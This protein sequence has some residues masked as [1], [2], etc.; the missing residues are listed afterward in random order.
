MVTIEVTIQ[1]CAILTES[2]CFNLRRVSHH[3]SSVKRVSPARLRARLTA[4]AEIKRPDSLEAMSVNLGFLVA[5]LGIV[6]A[7]GWEEAD[8][9]IEVGLITY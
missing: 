1:L 6:R 3:S 8:N 9:I 2:T 5:G 4:I 7:V